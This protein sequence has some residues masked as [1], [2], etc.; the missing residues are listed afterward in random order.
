MSCPS[1]PYRFSVLKYSFAGPTPPL[2]KT[3]DATCGARIPPQRFT[4]TNPFH[5]PHAV[6]NAHPSVR[7]TSSRAR[8]RHVQNP[9][10]L[11]FLPLPPDTSSS[12]STFLH[13]SLPPPIPPPAS[14]YPPQHPPPTVCPGFPLFASPPS[15]YSH[16]YTPRSRSRALRRRYGGACRMLTPHAGVRVLPQLGAVLGQP[17]P[18]N[19]A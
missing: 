1:F 3:W 2:V 15:T 10:P 13:A 18:Q 5:S 14:G 19:L 9:K 6:S 11:I 4:T 16:R 12:S 17:P 8:R 7:S